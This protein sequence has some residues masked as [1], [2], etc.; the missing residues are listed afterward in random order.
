[1]V[2][3]DLHELQKLF[4]EGDARRRYREIVFE[5]DRIALISHPEVYDPDIMRKRF[6]VLLPLGLMSPDPEAVI[7]RILALSSRLREE[8]WVRAVASRLAGFWVGPADS[9]AAR[10][11][12]ALKKQLGYEHWDDADW[13][14]LGPAAARVVR[15][16]EE[17]A[18][19][20]D[21]AARLGA[22][23]GIIR[24]GPGVYEGSL[25]LSGFSKLVLW[26]SGAG[27]T[28]I[29]GSVLIERTKGFVARD[30]TVDA[31]PRAGET[32][33]ERYAVALDSVDG[34]TLK[35]L[36]ISG[37]EETGLW[38]LR[39]SGVLVWDCIFERNH[40]D[41]VSEGMGVDVQDSVIAQPPPAPSE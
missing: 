30:L 32:L 36:D 24:V 29:R 4:W 9:A 13:A 41:L 28:V 6:A 26:G 34:A 31:S 19:I 10:E 1:M 38:S 25:R 21:A 37:A 7:Q 33:G 20:S 22:D 5:A 2:N 8:E 14:A 3:T 15:V 11:L 12:A 18:S 40:D 16:P 23:G 35:H 39:S 27:V 17:A